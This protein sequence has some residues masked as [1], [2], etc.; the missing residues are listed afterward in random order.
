MT[1]LVLIVPPRII[2]L[3]L[4]VIPLLKIHMLPM[5]LMFPI[6]VVNHLAMIPR[7]IV[8]VTNIIGTNLSLAPRD[9]PRPRQSHRQNY[10]RKIPRYITH[11]QFLRCKYPKISQH[12]LPRQ[13]LIPLREILYVLSPP[14][15]PPAQKPKLSLIITLLMHPVAMNA[16][17][18]RQAFIELF[19]ALHDWVPLGSLNDLAGVRAANPGGKLSAL[20]S[21]APPRTLLASRPAS[22]PSAS[23]IRIDSPGGGGSAT[24]CYFLASC[25]PG[26]SR[27]SSAPIPPAPRVIN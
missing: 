8:A 6:V 19:P 15:L 14:K 2:F 11:Q 26:G 16:L 18:A 27:I 5:R 4:R 9:K 22:S 13:T 23:P 10:H 25:A 1:Q 24:R 12:K 20:R 3:L 21:L 17:L 7:M